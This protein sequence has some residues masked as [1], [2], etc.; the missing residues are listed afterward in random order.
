KKADLVIMPKRGRGSKA[1]DKA[2]INSAYLSSAN[3]TVEELELRRNQLKTLIKMGK[4]RGYL[5][6]AEIND[7]LPDDV[8]DGEVIEAM[9]STFHDMGITVY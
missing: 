3:A 4:E 5:T 9:V 6:F 8:T 2:L 7:H 1:K